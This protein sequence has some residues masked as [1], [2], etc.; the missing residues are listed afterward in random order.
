MLRNRHDFPFFQSVSA[1]VWVNVVRTWI[2]LQ[3]CCSYHEPQWTIDLRF[4][5]WCLVLGI[6]LGCQKRFVF[7]RCLLHSQLEVSSLLHLRS[8]LLPDFYSSLSSVLYH[9]LF[10]LWLLR[11]GKEP[12]CQC[13]RHKRCR[14]TPWVAKIPWRR[15]WQP[16]PLF[17]PGKSHGQRILEGYSP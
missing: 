15:A 8:G 14:F 6:R 11:C 4:L 9:L 5:W 13:P 3:V 2:R 16:T 17:L 1:G 10:E 7:P 12:A